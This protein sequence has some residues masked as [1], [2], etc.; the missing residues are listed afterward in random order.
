M[1]IAIGNDHTAVELK[2]HVTEFV[3]KMGHEVV[4]FGTDSSESA[5]YAIY[6]L[7]VAQAVT[8]GE[9]DRGIV[10]CGTGIGISIAAN[11]V[12]GIRCAL[13]S[14]P[15]SAK[16]T[17]QHNDANV[18]A[19]GAR[20]VGPVLA[21]SIVEAYLTTEFEGG[22]HQRRIDQISKIEAEQTI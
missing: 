19:M 15:C 2:N 9:V 5:D 22:R 11:K 21:E 14:E 6:A 4:N 20:M 17:R 1:R 12:K 3:K 18:L 8:S 7:K 10:I 13:C 16:L